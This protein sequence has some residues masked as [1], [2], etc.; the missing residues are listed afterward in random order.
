[1]NIEHVRTFLDVMETGNFNRTSERLYVTQSTVSAR[2][3]ALED[4]L[5]GHA[6]FTRGRHGAA[7]TDYARKFQTHAVH[8]V[9]IWQQARHELAL[10]R[11]Y[12]AVLRIGIQFSYWDRAVDE[13]VISMRTAHPKVAV[14][15]EADYSPAI[16]NQIGEG[17]LDIG[18]LYRPDYA[19][20]VT[21]EKLGTER[22]IMYST[23]TDHY[24]GIDPER[25]LFI[26][27]SPHFKAAHLNL[28]PELQS[29]P[30]SMG[31]GS[32]AISYLRKAGGTAYLPARMAR[33]YGGDISL[34]RIRDAEVIE[35][36][37]YA[38]Y[39][40]TSEKIAIVESAIEQLKAII[41]HADPAGDGSNK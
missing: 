9:R 4:S 3:K 19:Q 15:V 7:P 35:Q 33:R 14:H 28:Y 24:A 32:M 39:P 34:T 38:V 18:I 29:S 13:W 6:L 5:G 20:E 11:D 12:E 26:D 17:A 21:I 40:Q 41:G 16:L 2:I 36:P 27:W 31:V 37:V 30:V 1:M 8:L 23:D 22:F 25:Y 10:P